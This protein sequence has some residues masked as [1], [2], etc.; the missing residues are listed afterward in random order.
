MAA[1]PNAHETL[2]K[3]VRRSCMEIPLPKGTEAQ[4]KERSTLC[5]YEYNE[6]TSRLYYLLLILCQ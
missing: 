1:L 2:G 6:A 3:A 5:Q 4:S